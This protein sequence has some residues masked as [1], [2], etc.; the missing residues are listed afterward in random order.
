MNKPF[1]T[2]AQ[3]AMYKYQP[4]SKYY[5]QSM[6]Y[7]FA[8]E[9]LDY[10]KVNKFIIH[11]AIQWFLNRRISNNIWKIYFSDESV[12]YIKIL[13]LQDDSSRGIEIKTFD[14]NTNAGDV[15]G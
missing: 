7:I 15:F 6:A 1:I 13:E 3:L 14:F 2:Q 10:S 9:L 5:G 11:E 12:A 4:S 8:S